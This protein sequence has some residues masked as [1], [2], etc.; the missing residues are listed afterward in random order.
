MNPT[1]KP[2]INASKIPRALH[3]RIRFTFI[4]LTRLVLPT[5]TF[6]AFHQEPQAQ[7]SFANERDGHH[8]G[9]EMRSEGR[10]QEVSKR[11]DHVT[12][13]ADCQD[14]AQY[15]GQERRSR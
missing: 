4:A 10:C 3:F 8:E 11:G 9:H 7:R 14:Y 2:K 5:L 6:Y 15:A 12:R 13:S 1:R